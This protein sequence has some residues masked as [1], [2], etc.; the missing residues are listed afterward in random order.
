MRSEESRT[1][2]HRIIIK[3][4]IDAINF[5]NDLIWFISKEDI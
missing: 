3:I 4:K 2:S 5:R 1:W